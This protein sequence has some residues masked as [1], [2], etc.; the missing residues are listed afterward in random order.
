MVAGDLSAFAELEL[1][2][3]EVTLLEAAAS[4]Y[5]EVVGFDIRAGLAGLGFSPVGSK[6]EMDASQDVTVNKAK[7]ADKAYN[8]MNK[9]L[10]G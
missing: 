4:E 5:P 2:D 3:E 7:S 6:I 9:Y 10:R 1:T 8:A